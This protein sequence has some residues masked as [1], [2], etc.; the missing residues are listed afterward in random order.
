MVISISR[1]CSFMVIQDPAFSQR[2]SFARRASA[3]DIAIG[4]RF[5]RLV[6]E[7]RKYGGTIA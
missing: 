5:C 3:E 1:V 7:S 6:N 4:M 2:Y